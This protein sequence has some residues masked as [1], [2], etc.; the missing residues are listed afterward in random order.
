M[1]L[2]PLTEILGVQRAGHLLR[3]AIGG[4]DIGTINSFALLTPQEAIEQL[5]PSDISGLPNPPFPVDPLTNQEWIST[6]TTEANSE[7]FQLGRFLNAWMVAQQVGSGVPA[8]YKLPYTFR[9]RLVFFIHTLFTTK[10]SIVNNSR[11]IYYQQA[12]FRKYALD[13]QDTERPNPDYDPN[14][15][16]NPL[17]ATLPVAVNLRE[18]TKKIS[19]DNAMLVFLDG[20]LNVNGNPNENYARELLELYSVGR[21]LE[22]YIPRPE[23]DGDYHYFTET[24]VQEG[25]R[26]LSGFNRDFTFGTIDPE[27]DLPRGIAKG[28]PNANRHD[29][30][31]KT[32]SN[33]MGN[34]V[35]L[36]NADLIA[37]A[38]GEELAIDEIGQLVDLIYDQEETA[39]HICRKLYRFYVYHEVS[40]S[41]QDDII[42]ELAEVFTSNAG[43]D[44]TVNLTLKIN[45]TYEDELTVEINEGEEYSFGP[46]V[47]S[48]DDVYTEIFKSK[49]GCDSIVTLT[50]YVN[51][52]IT[53]TINNENK[54]FETFTIKTFI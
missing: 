12:L 49:S 11:A 41:L 33:R 40:Q 26:V 18:L 29:T 4:A 21:G 14:E 7:E 8:D 6:G 28:R 5:I 47:L 19:L 35:I 36:P 46:L 53:S 20:R 34:A 51:S 30:G 39:I 10:Q 2:N 44:S 23:F 17:P 16:E 38:T 37:R 3:R 52:V 50:L 48:K 31:V 24:D 9:E 1:P 15:I 42:A 43:C 45:P 25:A 32:F 22:G 13:E 54:A 27:T